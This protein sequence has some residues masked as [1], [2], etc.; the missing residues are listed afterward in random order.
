M[1]KHFLPGAKHFDVTQRMLTEMGIGPAGGYCVTMRN[2]QITKYGQLL[3]QC[4][5]LFLIKWENVIDTPLLSSALDNNW[6]SNGTV[7]QVG[8]TNGASLLSK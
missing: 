3:N 5:K 2:G 8:W 4:E 6:R 7:R 1:H